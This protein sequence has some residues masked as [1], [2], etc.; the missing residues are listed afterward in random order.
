MAAKWSEPNGEGPEDLK[1]SPWLC[2][3]VAHCVRPPAW[4]LVP[5][6]GAGASWRPPCHSSAWLARR[7]VR[8]ASF[9]PPGRPAAAG[10][11]AQGHLWVLPSLWPGNGQPGLGRGT[12]L[13]WMFLWGLLSL[14]R[15][16]LAGVPLRVEPWAGPL[17]LQGCWAAEG[18]RGSQS[19]PST[20]DKNTPQMVRA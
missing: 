2:P 15:W 9:G 14:L 10:L 12:Y 13:W 11:W 8:A 20:C 18:W 19:F 4:V 16:I 6:L 7:P 5:W 3:Q 17:V 1:G